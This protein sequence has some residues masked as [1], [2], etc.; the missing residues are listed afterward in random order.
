MNVLNK[1]NGEIKPKTQ[2]KVCYFGTYR[3]EYSR[4][5]IMIKGLRKNNVEVIECHENLWTGI[6]DR[7]NAVEHGIINPKLWKR[8]FGAYFRLFKKFKNLPDFDVL[9]V[10]YPGQFDIFFAKFLT[11]FKRKPII[12]DV[13]MSIYLISKE[14][15]LHLKNPISVKILKIIEHL[16]LRLPEKLII[17][18]K[19]YADWFYQNFKIPIEKFCVVPTGADDDVFYLDQYVE[20]QPKEKF[21]VLYYGTYIPNHGVPYMLEAAKY[22]GNDPTIIFQFIG[23]GPELDDC[24]KLIKK[25]NLQNVELYSWMGQ[26]ELKKYIRKADV[27][28]GAFG[29]TPQSL[30]T[31][32]NKIYEG[33]AMGKVVITGDSEVIDD[34]F[35]N[36]KEIVVCDREKPENL[37]TT[38]KELYDKPETI[39]LIS[40]NAIN[41]YGCEFSTVKNGLRFV[42]CLK[43]E[44]SKP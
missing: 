28:L 2:I 24:Q 35:E 21:I 1:K 12:W 16:A 41:I 29:I 32:Q 27:V 33:M 19:Q 34:Q 25:H 14:R 18:T 42:N 31:I 30:M 7:V 8:M 6:D 44:L 13:F 20:Y 43:A 36:Y 3:T 5:R 39:N 40:K 15:N 4:N 26:E 10:G 22:L 17:D 11:I 23:E 37:A 38:I 9:I